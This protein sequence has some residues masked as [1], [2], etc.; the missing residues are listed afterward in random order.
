MTSASE[1]PFAQPTKRPRRT[2][3]IVLLIIGGLITLI[4]LLIIGL[5]MLVNSS[6]GDAQKVS[7][8]F[9]EAVQAGDGAAAYALTGPAFRAATTEDELTQ[10]VQNLA[11]ALSK[12]KPSPRGKSINVSSD[13]GKIAVFVYTLGAGE[14]P[15]YLKTQIREE[16]DG[17][18]V[19]SLRSSE[20]E[21]TTDVE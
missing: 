6:T 2:L 17:W 15:V 7:D 19:L 21:L 13:S 10:L 20:S 9:V 18:Q 16:D 3:K 12:D 5:V 1:L 4:A 14:R 8:Q 11:P